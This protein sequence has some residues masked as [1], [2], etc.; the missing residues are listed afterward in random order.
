[1]RI[2]TYVSS[3]NKA[4]L[5]ER[6][7]RS[8]CNQSHA[9]ERVVVCEDASTD[10]SRAIIRRL[11][12]EYTN[13]GVIEYP[14]KAADWMRAYINFAAKSDADYI[15]LLAADDCI[16]QGFYKACQLAA[17]TAAGV[18]L[19]NVRN[20]SLAGQIFG[21]SSYQLLLGHQFQTPNLRQWLHSGSLLGGT[22]TILSNAALQWLCRNGADRMGPWFD[23]VG[24][25]AAAWALGI[26]YLPTC[27][28]I[29]TQEEGNYGG[30]NRHAEQRAKEKP[31]AAAF[32]AEPEVVAALGEELATVL[33]ARVK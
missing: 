8:A 3:H 30:N 1:M 24:Y 33:C 27:Y 32:F 14:V 16:E 2:D 13:L 19:S 10:D 9:P 21:T 6:S 4:T 26:Y 25:P 15:H 11:Q 18:I 7:I 23:S 5:I 29:F 28:G 12:S 22:G 31:G 17:P 20:V